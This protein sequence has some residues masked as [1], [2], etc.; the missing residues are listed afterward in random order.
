MNDLILFAI[1]FASVVFLGVFGT[2]ARSKHLMLAVKAAKEGKSKEEIRALIN[3]EPEG[4]LIQVYRRIAKIIFIGILLYW[5]NSW[6]GMT[7][8][9][10]P[11]EWQ[12]PIIRLVF[13]F[14]A[15]VALF[16]LMRSVIM[17]ISA[18]TDSTAITTIGDKNS[19]WETL[20]TRLLIA[21][22]LLSVTA[23]LVPVYFIV[24]QA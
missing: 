11:S 3:K 7:S 5:S 6:F 9:G 1:L 23:A 12:L 24:K 14:Q 8:A 18:F 16:V 22:C 10:L 19:H 21:A 15:T 13:G 4:P 17:I 2:I 20:E